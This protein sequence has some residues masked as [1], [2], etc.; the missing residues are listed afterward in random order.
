MLKLILKNIKRFLKKFFFFSILIQF[1]SRHRTYFKYIE[2]FINSLGKKHK[3]YICE[4]TFFYFTKF[5][6]G[7]KNF[8]NFLK[9]SQ[10]I[11]SDLDNFGCMYCGSHDRERHLFMFF[12]QIQL[13]EK[14]TNAKILHFAPEKNLELKI[15]ST[16]PETYIVADLY[17]YRKDILKI[18]AT[19]I[20]FESN[21]FD[22]VIANHVLEHISNYKK[23]LQEIYRVLKLKGFAILQTPYSKVLH[24]NF[25]DE[26]INTD[27]LRSYFYGQKDHVR[28]FGKKEFFKSLKDVGF[29]INIKRNNDFFNEE[30]TKYFGVNPNE[31]LIL[32]F[33]I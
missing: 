17:P 3:C 11:G 15:K 30:E 9:Q 32:V 24:N 23:A 1:I 31:D 2:L 26:G 12:D 27:Y 21:Y 6:G 4:K 19:N 25:E 28:L 29:Q 8:S 33:K 10:I 16:N 20:P 18:D 14:F 7:L 22:V 5:N 13:W